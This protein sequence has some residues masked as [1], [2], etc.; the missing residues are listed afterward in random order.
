GLAEKYGKMPSQITLRW[1]IQNK[2][3]PVVKSSDPQRMRQNLEI[4]DFELDEDDM[5]LMDSLNQ[6]KSSA[7]MP[8]GTDYE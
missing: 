3:S 7:G 4:F 6:N 8:K 1:V 5:N 2:V